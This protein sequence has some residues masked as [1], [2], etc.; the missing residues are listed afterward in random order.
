MCRGFRKRRRDRPREMP[1]PPEQLLS[2][3][4]LFES[5]LISIRDY[6]CR[7]HQS[8]PAAEEESAENSIVLMRQGTFCQHFGSKT[9]TADANHA[10]FFSKESSYRVSH[11]AGCG[12][13]GTVF[14]A[15]PDVL[16]ELG[17]RFPFVTAPCDGAIVRWH[18]DL[19]RHLASGHSDV[20]EAEVI[21]LDLISAVLES[22]L[23]YHGRTRTRRRTTEA[24]HA[25]RI[26]A[27]KRF[28]A[29][30]FSEGV[31]LDE[32]SRACH[33]SPFH[34]A[35]VFRERTGI[36]VHRY[37]NGLRLRAALQRLADGADDLTSL[38]LELG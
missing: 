35:R 16:G 28:L 34:F 37:M 36:S 9:V 15:R 12:D 5:K 4:P 26:E 3:R 38:A 20:L 23:V 11:P 32:A 31:T 2:F 21:A 19:L 10:V 13:R 25:E 33:L 22:A 18:Y 24:D 14:V 27:A 6:R 1:A 29:S 7:H 8:G 17:E 30:R